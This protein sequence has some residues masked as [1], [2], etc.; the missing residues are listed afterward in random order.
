MFVGTDVAGRPIGLP[1]TDALLRQLAD[2]KT[3]GNIVPPPTLTV[4]KQVLA[5][6]EVALGG[7]TRRL[8]PGPS[9]THL[10]PRGATASRGELAGRA[11]PEREAP[12]SRNLTTPIRPPERGDLDLRTSRMNTCRGRSM[13]PR[14]S[15]TTAHHRAAR[16]HEDACV[17][18][19]P[20]AHD[21]TDPG[22][23][24]RDFLPGAYVQ[25]LRIAGTA[26]DC[27]IVDER[28]FDGPIGSLIGGLEDKLDSHNRTAVDVTSGTLETR[29]STHALGALRQLVR[30]AVMHRSY[31]G[32]HSPI[33]VYWY[34]DRIE[35]NSPGGPYGRCRL[36]ISHSRASLRTA[37][38]WWRKRCECSTSYSDGVPDCL[39]H[40]VSYAPTSSRTRCSKS[41]RNASSV[42]CRRTVPHR[43]DAGLRRGSRTQLPAAEEVP[44]LGDG[45]VSPRYRTLSSRCCSTEAQAMQAMRRDAAA[46]RG[47]AVD[48]VAGRRV[49]CA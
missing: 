32:A 30:N 41:R 39:S 21:V 26:L 14:W 48:R 4:S 37:T 27:P 16:E 35:I 46:W 23:A 40:G 20:A 25:F 49:W 19:R 29:S 34:D 31:E 12:P 44:G 22:E 10:D 47:V 17:G 33:H 45:Q 13:R 28:L 24:P 36:R 8:A 5:G 1:I 11:H 9:G 15:R 3:D 42:P 7:A 2:I 38:R 43:D 6:H 18:R